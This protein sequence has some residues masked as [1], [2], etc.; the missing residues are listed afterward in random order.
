MKNHFRSAQDL[1]RATRTTLLDRRQAPDAAD[2]VQLR[3]SLEQLANAVPARDATSLADRLESI[4]K[5]VAARWTKRGVATL[6]FMAA[7]VHGCYYLSTDCFYVEINIE[8]SSGRVAEAKVH[9]IDAG[10]PNQQ[11]SASKN[12]PEIIQCLTHGEFQKFID[13]LEGLMSIYDIPNATAQNKSQGWNALAS[14]EADLA[15]LDFGQDDIGSKI[16]HGN[17]GFLQPRA[18][19][20]PLKMT[21]FVAP[22]EKL[23][24]NTKSLRK[25]NAQ[26][27]NDEDIGIY[28]TVC[29]EKCETPRHLPTVPLISPD[30][31][32]VPINQNNSVMLPAGFV[33]HLGQC[34]A[35]E[36]S[37]Y[38]EIVNITGISFVPDVS[39]TLPLLQLI[40]KSVS[41]DLLDSSNNR[42]MFVVRFL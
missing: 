6:N 18:G 27:I 9:H 29:I 8:G 25:L 21:Y 42:G 4:S 13:H 31:T 36:S 26:M 1:C 32:E 30:G 16:N 3:A 34:V 40:T 14:C 35:L 7:P 23:D 37:K 15:R 2:R 33:L 12:C 41:D 5:Q 19:G 11:T 20:L 38:H 39:K 24:M 28:A 10:Q 22:M 17:L